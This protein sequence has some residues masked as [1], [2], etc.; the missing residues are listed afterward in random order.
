MQSPLGRLQIL[1]T[2]KVFTSGLPLFVPQT[3]GGDSREARSQGKV[4]E[5][6]ELGML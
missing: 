4:L 3:I 1:L 5:D 2:R 6:T